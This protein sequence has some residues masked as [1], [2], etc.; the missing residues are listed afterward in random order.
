[1]LGARAVGIDVHGSLSKVASYC[2]GSDSI[3]IIQGSLLKPPI[4]QGTFDLVWSEGVI[5]H[6]GDPPGAFEKLA[7]LVKPGGRLFVWVY[8]NNEQTIYRKVRNFLKVGHR[9]PMPVLLSVCYF[10]AGCFHVG[11]RLRG[12]AKNS[13][14]QKERTPLRLH[15]FRLFDHISPTHNTQHSEEE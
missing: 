6:T 12:L 11:A 15:A 13:G 2:Q 3:C 10:L 14:R 8:W 1:S 9:L 7:R 4:R 5:H